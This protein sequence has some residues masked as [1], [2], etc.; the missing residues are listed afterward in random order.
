MT[1]SFI[2]KYSN[3]IGDE[4]CNDGTRSSECTS[5]HLVTVTDTVP[6]DSVGTRL[7]VFFWTVFPTTFLFI[8]SRIQTAKADGWRCHIKIIM[9]TKTDKVQ[10]WMFQWTLI[11]CRIDKWY[12]Q[13]DKVEPRESLKK[14][15][16]TSQKT[17]SKDNTMNTTEQITFWLSS[18]VHRQRT[19]DSNREKPW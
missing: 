9:N 6:Y 4:F 8:F 17:S 12:I 15:T 5:L 11:M 2:R 18:R 3:L 14:I 7:F 13:R 19:W 1:W 16:R 10:T